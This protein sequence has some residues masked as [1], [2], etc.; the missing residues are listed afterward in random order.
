MNKSC[1][2]LGNKLVPENYQPDNS[3]GTVYMELLQFHFY[4]LIV[5]FTTTTFNPQS[6]EA[7]H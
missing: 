2:I 1:Y 6:F 5:L 7:C 4:T 3:I